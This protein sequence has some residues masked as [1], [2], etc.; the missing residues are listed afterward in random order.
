MLSLDESP[1]ID[2]SRSGLVQKSLMKLSVVTVRVSCRSSVTV[3]VFECGSFFNLRFLL[4]D[5][6][7]RGNRWERTRRQSISRGLES[8]SLLTDK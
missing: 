2:L 3:R 8:L 5:V 6:T 4:T 1:G 7:N